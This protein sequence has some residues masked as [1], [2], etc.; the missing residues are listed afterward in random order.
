MEKSVD[1][2]YLEKA[3]SQEGVPSEKEV[4]ILKAC[5]WRDIEALKGHAES[6][7]GFMT[8]AIR[9]EACRLPLNIQDGLS[10]CISLS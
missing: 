1:A 3:E 10:F 7:G 4:A 5:Q 2:M 8:D 6:P 9:Q